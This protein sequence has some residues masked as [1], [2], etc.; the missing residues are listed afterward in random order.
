MD[1]YLRRAGVREGNCHVLR[2]TAAKWWID[3]RVEI[4]VVQKLLGLESIL[5][6][7]RYITATKEDKRRAVESTSSEREISL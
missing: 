7:Q 6:T 5:T 3:N 2:H 1:K 4:S